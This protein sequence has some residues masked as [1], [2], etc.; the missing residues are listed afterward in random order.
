MCFALRGLEPRP[1][2]SHQ[3]VLTPGLADGQVA[4][5]LKAVLLPTQQLSAVKNAKS[6]SHQAKCRTECDANWAKALG[7]LCEY[8]ATTQA[9]IPGFSPPA[10]SILIMRPQEL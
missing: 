10:W 9:P 8:T 7:V 6:P 5:A 4:S 3:A 2:L 1:A